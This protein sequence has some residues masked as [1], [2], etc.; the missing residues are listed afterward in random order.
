[1]FSHY[2]MCSLTI[3]CVLYQELYV[4]KAGYKT[5][6]ETYPDLCEPRGYVPAT[7]PRFT[8]GVCVCLSLSVCVC[9]CACVCARVHRR[10]F[11][12]R[13]LHWV[14]HVR[15]RTGY[16]ALH[17]LA[18]MR[19]RT[20]EHTFTN[21]VWCAL[22]RVPRQTMCASN[23]V[24]VCVCVCVCVYVC[25]SIDTRAAADYVRFKHLHQQSTFSL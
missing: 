24:C 5:F 20:R 15:A 1:M 23:T 10:A 19:S 3:E 22:T 4:L 18:T 13:Y 9:V 2:R 7:D 14:L 21:A 17:E 25:V 12:C 16:H 6:F 11:R 8:A